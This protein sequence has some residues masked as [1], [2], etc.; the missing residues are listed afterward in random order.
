MLEALFSASPVSLPNGDSP[1]RVPAPRP[2]DGIPGRLSE[3]KSKKY[4]SKCK[5]NITFMKTIKSCPAN[6]YYQ[7]G[8]NLSGGAF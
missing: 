4:L 5:V 7:T 3:A 6:Y 2:C 1:V 8:I